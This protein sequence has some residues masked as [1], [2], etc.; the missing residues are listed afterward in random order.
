MRAEYLE[1]LKAYNETD[2]SDVKVAI[3]ALH[4]ETAALGKGLVELQAGIK[5]LQEA[6]AA[7]DPAA[8]LAK[9]GALR[10]VADGLE[11]VVSDAR[12]PLPKYRTM[13]FLY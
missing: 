5:A 4:D 1:T 8:V 11:T 6:V 7:A 3:D 10:T 9:M 12:W 13:L 2:A